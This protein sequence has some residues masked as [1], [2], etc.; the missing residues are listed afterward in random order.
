M[1]AKDIA[2]T[3]DVPVVT[4]ENG[5]VVA[6]FAVGVEPI[7]DVPL[8]V[9]GD[10][11]CVFKYVDFPFVR[12]ADGTQLLKLPS[13]DFDLKFMTH[14]LAGSDIPKAN[15]YER[16]M[17]YLKKMR[18]AVPPLEEQRKAVKKIEKLEAKIAEAEAELS[19][20]ASKKAA[21]LDK[22]LS[23]RDMK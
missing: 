1:A 22:Y 2:P 5:E 23:M 18:I 20:S 21:I 6:G 19:R 13:S 17:K 7:T 14:Y 12:G 3:G 15:S 10:H 8:I 16:H 4:Q 9:F 11:T